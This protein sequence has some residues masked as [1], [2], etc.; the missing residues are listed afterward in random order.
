MVIVRT[1][2]SICLVR[3][4]VS[5]EKLSVRNSTSV[6]VVPSVGGKLRVS[7]PLLTKNVLAGLASLAG[8][9]EAGSAADIT[10]IAE[11]A[12]SDDQREQWKTILKACSWIRDTQRARGE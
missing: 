2:S 5:K 3:D 7:R 10:G 9:V 6:E 12:M 4:P 8:L 1:G 11:D